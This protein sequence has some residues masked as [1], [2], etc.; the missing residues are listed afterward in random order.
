MIGND[1]APVSGAAVTASK[2][3][4]SGSAVTDDSG[5]YALELPVGSYMVTATAF[6]FNAQTFTGVMV[7]AG[8]PTTRDFVLVPIPRHRVSGTVRSGGQPLAGATVTIANTPLP[9][10]HTDTAGQ[11]VID[12]VPEGTYQVVA[13]AGCF[14]DATANLTVDGDEVLDFS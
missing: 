1:G 4:T 12:G 14:D 7:T 3:G 10:A 2:T 6:G 11:Y 8:H 5:H 9:P 13:T